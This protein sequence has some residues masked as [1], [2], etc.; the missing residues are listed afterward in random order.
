M[1]HMV[2]QIGADDDDLISTGVGSTALPMFRE[3]GPSSRRTLGT[4]RVATTPVA[5]SPE[6]MPPI[7]HG[8]RD[9]RSRRSANVEMTTISQ[10]FMPMDAAEAFEDPGTFRWDGTATTANA[11][12]HHGDEDNMEDRGDDE[13][14]PRGV[15][16]PLRRKRAKMRYRQPP[17]EL[18]NAS[19]ASRPWYIMV[20]ESRTHQLFDHLGEEGRG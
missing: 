19:S 17:P 3:S 9:I 5:A 13:V 6:D 12:A 2:S 20:P 14:Q 4:S 10:K 16:L 8:K 15:G 1:F 7:R 18:S 11:S